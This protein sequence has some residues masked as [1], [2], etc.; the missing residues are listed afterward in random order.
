MLGTSLY[1][2]NT[3]YLDNPDIDDGEK[4]QRLKQQF[5]MYR[6]VNTFNDNPRDRYQSFL[7]QAKQV[8]VAGVD[9]YIMDEIKRMKAELER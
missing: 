2:Q 5:E 4:L 8:D 3:A 9:T 7:L 1:D 6:M